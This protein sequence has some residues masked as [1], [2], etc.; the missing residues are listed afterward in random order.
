[1]VTNGD[2]NTIDTRKTQV[3]LCRLSDFCVIWRLKDILIR[4]SRRRE[5]SGKFKDTS[6]V[7][8][9]YPLR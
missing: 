4:R 6:L 8:F 9:L 3:R 5:Q 7:T 1:M 2:K